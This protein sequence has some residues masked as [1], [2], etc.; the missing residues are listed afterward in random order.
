MMSPPLADICF[1][2]QFSPFFHAKSLLIFYLDFIK[3]QI[4]L[5]VRTK[6]HKLFLQYYT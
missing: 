5:S 4:F 3:L 6:M 2:T 1:P